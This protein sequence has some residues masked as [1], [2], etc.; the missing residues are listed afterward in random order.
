MEAKD[1]KLKDKESSFSNSDL[2]KIRTKSVYTIRKIREQIQSQ[3]NTDDDNTGK[4]GH[5]RTT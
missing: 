2:N 5:L 4:I 1:K 3:K